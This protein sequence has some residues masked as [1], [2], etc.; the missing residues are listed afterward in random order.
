VDLTVGEECEDLN[1]RGLSNDGCSSLCQNEA[2]TWSDKQLGNFGVI[3]AR[4]MAFDERRNQIVVAGGLRL[5][6]VYGGWTLDL[7]AAE[8][9][10][11]PMISADEP[12]VRAAAAMVYDTARNEIIMFGGTIS[13]EPT[14]EMWRLKNNAWS[15]IRCNISPPAQFGH[16][17]VYDSDRKKTVLIPGRGGNQETWEWDGIDWVRVAL[18]SAPPERHGFAA[19]YD[20]KRKLVVTSGGHRDE[21]VTSIDSETWEL[22]GGL[23]SLAAPSRVPPP[24][25]GAASYFD[26]TLNAMVVVGGRT[27]REPRSDIWAYDGNWRKL[28]GIVRFDKRPTAIWDSRAKRGIVDGAIGNVQSTFT[29]VGGI[30][31]PVAELRPT[32]PNEAHPQ[33][34]YDH[35]R[36]ELIVTQTVET[37]AMAATWIWNGKTWR[38][39][40]SAPLPRKRGAMVF[41]R[42]RH[43]AVLFG[44]K[45]ADQSNLNDT[46]LWD[47]GNW[48]QVHPAESPSPRRGHILGYDLVHKRV[49]MFGGGASQNV[50]LSD[51]WAWD[52]TNWEQLNPAS[53][54]SNCSMPIAATDD[55]RLRVVVLCQ[56]EG[57]TW[58]WNGETWLAKGTDA[59]LRNLKSASM[60]YDSTRGL[61]ILIGGKKSINVTDKSWLWD[62]VS[63]IQSG[64]TAPRIMYATS[65]YFERTQSTIVVGPRSTQD[66]TTVFSFRSSD[67]TAKV[68]DCEYASDID[69]DALI[70]CADPDCFGVC[71]PGC[72]PGKVCPN[73]PHCGD[74]VCAPIEN[75]SMCPSDCP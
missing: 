50:S 63:W 47:G 72:A 65:A 39:N 42:E 1:P 37:Q 8:L 10:W 29:V 27:L 70:G 66:I 71:N 22:D 41:D 35:F 40:R 34:A 24:R 30:L 3:N 38:I 25:R 48:V 4:S 44:G 31:T 64:V 55:R 69:G 17:L 12:E 62:G 57:S 61:V 67:T 9:Q 56:K 45:A 75:Q 36:G 11:L 58:E 20:S 59:T 32:A 15:L 60:S 16:A 21:E 73:L 54:P 19:A 26:A 68:E 43:S 52:G 14:N 33:V 74:H 53:S 49:I 28:Q 6:N 5:D 13:R 7:N 51:T 18:S 23:W 2:G 46:N